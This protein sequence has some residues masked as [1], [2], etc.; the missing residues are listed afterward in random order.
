MRPGSPSRRALGS[1]ALAA[2]LASCTV[3]GGEVAAPTTTGE[4]D[5]PS[6]RFEEVG[7]AIVATDE[8]PEEETD[9][10]VVDE[11]DLGDSANEK[12]EKIGEAIDAPSALGPDAASGQTG[13]ASVASDLAFPAATPSDPPDEWLV[14]PEAYLTGA[15]GLTAYYAEDL[16]ELFPPDGTVD[17]E[18]LIATWTA[19]GYDNSSVI[20]DEDGDPPLTVNVSRFRDH[21]SAVDAT[22]AHLADL[23][24]SAEVAEPV[25]D[26]TGIR[27]TSVH[28][29]VKIV[30]VAGR[31][32]VDLTAWPSG[33]AAPSDI[34]ALEGWLDEIYALA[35]SPGP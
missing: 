5:A 27:M 21:A 9:D 10:T 20:Y 13:C 17:R 3:S 28:G 29:P 22:R 6:D 11:H 7:D 15:E 30:V 23:C 1:L 34:A 19:A 16:E 32:E 2:L 33:A 14:F 4:V 12:F 8:E 25:D 26:G 24:A 35:E 31:F 18:H